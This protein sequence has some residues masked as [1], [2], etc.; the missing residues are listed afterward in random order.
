MNDINK[1]I[2]QDKQE[3]ADSG[4]SKTTALYD[5]FAEV[6]H[7]TFESGK[8]KGRDAWERSMDVARQKMAAAG[9]F[10]AEQGE[11]FK[12]YLRRDLD[13][14]VIDA[15]KLGKEAKEALH[16]ARLGAGALSTFG[17]LMH[18]VGDTLTAFSEKV[19]EKLLYQAGEITMAGTLTCTSCGHKI[20]LKKTSVV[21]PCPAC[22]STSFS[23]GY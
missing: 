23:K 21:P 22:Q 17:K 13:Q 3:E 2:Q 12:L 18:A 14:T 10:S 5:R 20:H 15:R 7:N 16:P 1:P 9:E 11:A 6:T 8:E 4:E 19:E